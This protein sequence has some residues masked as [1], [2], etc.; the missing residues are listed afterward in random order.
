MEYKKNTIFKKYNIEPNIE[1]AKLRVLF[2]TDP[3]KRK[4]LPVVLKIISSDELLYEEELFTIHNNNESLDEYNKVLEILDSTKKN[5]ISSEIKNLSKYLIDIANDLEFYNK[6]YYSSKVNSKQAK[7]IFDEFL[8]CIFVK[9]TKEFNNSIGEISNQDLKKM[10]NSI[11]SIFEKVE[12]FSDKKKDF[13]E[14]LCDFLNNS[15]TLDTI[16]KDFINRLNSFIFLKNIVKDE[17]FSSSVK[18]LIDKMSNDIN[19]YGDT[20]IEL[21]D[22]I[23]DAFKGK[24]LKAVSSFIS[25]YISTNL[26]LRAD[27]SVTENKKCYKKLKKIQKCCW[28]YQQKKTI[29]DEDFDV[30]TELCDYFVYAG[31]EWITLYND[32]YKA[33]IDDINKD[34]IYNLLKIITD[35]LPSPEVLRVFS[36]VITDITGFNQMLEYIL[37]THEA[38]VNHTSEK[39]INPKDVDDFIAKYYWLI[40]TNFDSNVDKIFFNNIRNIA[41]D[42]LEI[43][44]KEVELL[45]NRFLDYS[46]RELIRRSVLSTYLLFPGDWVTSS[47]KTIRDIFRDLGEVFTGS[48]GDSEKMKKKYNILFDSMKKGIKAVFTCPKCSFYIDKG[49]K[50]C[51]KCEVILDWIETKKSNT[52]N[53]EE[54]DEYDEYDEEDDEEDDEKYYD[55]ESIYNSSE[56]QTDNSVWL[57]W[58]IVGILI[59]LIAV[60]SSI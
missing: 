27:K 3:T 45:N 23:S 57:W 5:Y 14:D 35:K 56:S 32:A 4:D 13:D 7:K 15:L 26:Y 17:F 18:Y 16:G 9:L 19:K 6:F 24:E 33:M 52:D 31:E 38:S 21:Y 10:Y 54:Y 47:G 50:K 11:T 53:S 36:N 44:N 12:R 1:K 28:L 34:T 39:Y 29:E 20:L 60:A 25:S 49:I 8:E 59:F 58:I 37:D 30:L 2:Q 46:S 55:S 48:D 40:Y 41:Y 42:I 22:E 43:H 51:P